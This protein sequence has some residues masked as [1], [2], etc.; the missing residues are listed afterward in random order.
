MDGHKLKMKV[1]VVIEYDA[2][3]K[4]YAAYCPELPGCTSCGDTEQG[5]LRQFKQ[6]LKLYFEPK[7]VKLSKHA[8]IMEVTLR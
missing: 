1:R 3:A 2:V 4:S 8:R 5:A 6:A 7:P